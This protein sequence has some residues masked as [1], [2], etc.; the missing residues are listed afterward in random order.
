[1]GYRAC[2]CTR[3]P[4]QSVI[5]FFRSSEQAF[6]EQQFR[7]YLRKQSSNHSGISADSSVHSE[8]SARALISSA[9]CSLAA[10]EHVR[11]VI[12]SALAAPDCPSAHVEN[13]AISSAL[14]ALQL[15][16]VA[17]SRSLAVQGQAWAAMSNAPA[18]L[19]QAQ[20]TSSSAKRL[21]Y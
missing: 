18:A 1:M 20:A 11:A 16:R 8:R 21:Q 5:Q 17:I 13:S 14:K 15:A 4:H 3:K 7:M 10:A 9:N 19:G 2:P 6:F 12:S